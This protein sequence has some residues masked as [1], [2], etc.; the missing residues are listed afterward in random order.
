MPRILVH[1]VAY[2]FMNILIENAESQEYLTEANVWSKK[3][4]DGKNF[5]GVKNALVIAKKEAIGK[6]NIVWYLAQTNQFINMEHGRG[7]VSASAA[8][9]A[10]A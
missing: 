4:A 5:G 8:A 6:F 3:P 1:D 2:P 10:T 7:T 9:T